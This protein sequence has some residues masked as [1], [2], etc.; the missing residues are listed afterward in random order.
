MVSRAG[1]VFDADGALTDDKIR[2]QLREFLA[3]FV[4]FV[5]QGKAA[6]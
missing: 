5:A 1:G 2:A 4:Q 3:G 6:S